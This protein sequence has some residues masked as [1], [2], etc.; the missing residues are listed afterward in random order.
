MSKI[1]VAP[2]KRLMI[3]C[4][5][6]CGAY[7][8]ARLLHHVYHLDRGTIVLHWLDGNPRRFKTYVGNRISTIMELIPPEKWNHVSGME[9][10]ADCASR[11]LFPS[12]LLQHPLWWNGPLLLK[13]SPT[14]WPKQSPLPLCN[15][16][17]EEREATHFVVAISSSPVVPFDQ[18]SS[19]NRLKRVSAWIIRFIHNCRNGSED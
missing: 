13:L 7:L 2:I 17:E 1:K 12:E 4:R 8:L 11:G 15:L 5:E 14:D 6:L 9:N 16:P 10:Q 18:Y 3:P 19:F